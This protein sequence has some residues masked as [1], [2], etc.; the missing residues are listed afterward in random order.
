MIRKLVA[1]ALLASTLAAAAVISQ[2]DRAC[3]S[4]GCGS[5]Y[6]TGRAGRVVSSGGIQ[7]CVPCNKADLDPGE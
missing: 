5:C 4:G 2:P 7:D 6:N 1:I 3:A